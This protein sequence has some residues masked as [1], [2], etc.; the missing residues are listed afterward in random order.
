MNTILTKKFKE[1]KNI[2]LKYN[3]VIIAFSGGVDSTLL[4]RLAKDSCNK[5]TLITLNFS[6]FPAFEIQDSICLAKSLNMEHK[7]INID[8][9]EIPHFTE[10]N[11]D[12]CYHCKKYLFSA[13]KKYAHDKNFEA[14]F[15][16]TNADDTNDYRPGR[17][18]LGEL[19]IISPLKMIGLTKQ[20]IR[21]ISH[22]FQLPTSSKPSY[23]CLASRFPYEE[24]ITKNKLI[25]VGNTEKEIRSLGFT[26]F[27]VRSHSDIARLEFI[28]AEI[29]S[30]W[31]KRSQIET[32][33]KECGFKYVAI[34]TGG[35][36][37]GAMNEVLSNQDINKFLD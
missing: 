5:V 10:N 36:R 3:S 33:C 12:R 37:T 15:D 30:A 35:Y 6:A 23:A 9:Q 32:I 28:S 21:K 22:E 8:E 4:A 16:G 14:I 18:A 31:N 2:F 26:Q 11:Y 7:I 1:L 25:R 24:I 20:E 27:R 17:K 19:G 13:L 34:D 29:D